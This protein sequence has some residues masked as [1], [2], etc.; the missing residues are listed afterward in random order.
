MVPISILS[1]G[2]LSASGTV[3]VFDIFCLYVNYLSPEEDFPDSLLMASV[4]ILGIGRVSEPTPKNVS[5]PPLL[6][7]IR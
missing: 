3:M 6:G 5:K 1:A 2:S 4:D 7:I